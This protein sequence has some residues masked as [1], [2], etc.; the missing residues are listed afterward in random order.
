MQKFDLF[1]FTENGRNLFGQR[2]GRA[3]EYEVTRTVTGKAEIHFK[4]GFIPAED[5]TTA[6]IAKKDLINFAIFALAK[7]HGTVYVNFRLYSAT[8]VA[9]DADTLEEISKAVQKVREAY[10]SRI[11]IY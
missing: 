6:Q 11:D 7:T 2:F 8:V 10:F 5:E 4:P 3:I 9:T 1:L